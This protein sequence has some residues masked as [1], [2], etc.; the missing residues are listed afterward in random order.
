MIITPKNWGEFARSIATERNPLLHSPSAMERFMAIARPHIYDV[1]TPV[2]KFK[3]HNSCSLVDFPNEEAK[4]YYM[5]AEQRLA[6][7]QAKL[8]Q[9]D[10]NQRGFAMLAIFNEYRMAA[11]EAMAEV[12]ADKM[13]AAVVKGERVAGAALC[14]R[15]P[16]A[17]ICRT[18]V[19]K[20]GYSRDDISMIWGG[21]E[22][23]NCKLTLQ[24]AQS[25][26]QQIVAKAAEGNPF[27][28]SVMRQIQLLVTETPKQREE[29]LADYGN[30]DMR[31]GPQS[32]ADRQREIDRFQSGKTKFALFSYAAGGVGLSLHHTDISPKGKP[33]DLLPRSGFL[34]PTYSAQDFVQ[35][36]GRLHR[37]VFSCS[38]T[39]QTIMFF[40][41]TIQEAVMSTVSNKLRCLKKVVS[42]REQWFSAAW[43]KKVQHEAEEEVRNMTEQ[44]LNDNED[45]VL[46]DYL[47]GDDDNNDND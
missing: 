9:T 21:D 27:P 4:Q 38:D 3:S 35:G 42:S 40:K 14:F 47:D 36:L 17:S 19:R 18:L 28:R 12:V 15:K 31:L 20:Y 10:G 7:K 22:L 24:D 45:I 44:Q 33:I 37:S 26:A 1:R 8:S 34:S 13:H 46:E 25:L 39:D 5:E 23:F 6:E 32:H 30:E 29:R 16:L 2:G 11:E 43:D 41:G